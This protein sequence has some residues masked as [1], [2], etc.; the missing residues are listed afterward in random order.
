MKKINFQTTR[1]RWVLILGIVTSPSV[2]S[3]VSRSIT[4]SFNT[5][6]ERENKDIDVNVTDYKS[7]F[8]NE[9][10]ACNCEYLNFV[11]CITFN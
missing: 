2:L 8:P 3:V 1:K 11:Q 5:G 4:D 10:T 6:N 9:T 7:A